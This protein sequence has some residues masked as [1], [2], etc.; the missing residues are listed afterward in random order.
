L[1]EQSQLE[2]MP[3]PRP[4]ISEKEL[5]RAVIDCAR[6]FGWRVAHFRSVP[7]KRGPR[8]IWETPV[9]GDGAGFPDLVL[10]R[11]EVLWIELKV[12][13]NTLSDAQAEWAQA[14]QGAGQMFH[15]W[16][17]RDWLDGVIEARLR[18]SPALDAA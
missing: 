15:V 17:D 13:A 4:T 14:L 6:I 3:A 8:V 11:E 12:G 18:R 1:S 5:Q 2:G 7:V 16:T 9:Q 10:V